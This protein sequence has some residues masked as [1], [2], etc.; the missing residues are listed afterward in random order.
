MS[1]EAT[2][3]LAIV[4]LIGLILARIPIAVAMIGSNTW[5]SAC[6]PS[7]PIAR[8]VT[9]TPSCIAAMKRGGTAVSPSTCLALRL[10]SSES[11]WR[12]VRRTVTSAYSAATKKPFRRISATTPSSSRKSVMQKPQRRGRRY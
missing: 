5:T 6:S 11:S 9:V 2:A 8:E 1:S 7:A 3:L 12:R 10:P 4:V